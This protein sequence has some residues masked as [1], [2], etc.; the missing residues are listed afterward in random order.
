MTLQSFSVTFTRV[1]MTYVI[2]HDF[3]GLQN[4]LTNFHRALRTAGMPSLSCHL[5]NS[6][7]AR[8]GWTQ[9][10]V[11]YHYI[12]DKASPDCQHNKKLRDHMKW[13]CWVGCVQVPIS[14]PLKL[15]LYLVESKNGVILKLGVGVI[16][17]HWKWC[18]LI[19]H[20]LL[21]NSRPL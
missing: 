12:T 18:C 5:T 19:D 7:K 17:S 16:Q 11:Y 14:I 13:Q 8:K 10:V 4:G 1:S 6:V 21:S 3:A 15:C 9:W 20:T 2:F